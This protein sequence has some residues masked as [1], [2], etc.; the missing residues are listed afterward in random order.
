[1]MGRGPVCLQIAVTAGPRPPTKTRR[2]A[3]KTIAISSHQSRNQSRNLYTATDEIAAVAK[4]DTMQMMARRARSEAK[5]IVRALDAYL[6][7]EGDDALSTALIHEAGG[8]C[9]R[10][11]AALSALYG[12]PDSNEKDGKP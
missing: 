12:V 3:T 10:L 1:M 6:V 5:C 11:A 8:S 2:F 7:L 9:G 4:V